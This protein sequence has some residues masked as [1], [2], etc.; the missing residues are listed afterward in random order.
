MFDKVSRLS[1]NNSLKE[2]LHQK[3]N[4]NWEKKN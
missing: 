2:E 1:H 3:W 4:A